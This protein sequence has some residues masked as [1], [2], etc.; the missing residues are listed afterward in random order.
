MSL[1]KDVLAK[2]NW[3]KEEKKIELFSILWI[4]FELNVVYHCLFCWLQSFAKKNQNENFA[5]RSKARSNFGHWLSSKAIQPN[6]ITD[7]F[8]VCR[9]QCID[10]CL[11]SPRYQ[12]FPGIHWTYLYDHCSSYG[13][14]L[15]CYCRF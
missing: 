8:T 10:L 6:N 14:Y 3:F 7:I 12:R 11:S 9:E 2:M 4:K 15:F 5:V 13:Y 1:R